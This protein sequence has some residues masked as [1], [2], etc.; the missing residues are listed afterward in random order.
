MRTPSSG[1]ARP[2]AAS[3]TT[4]AALL[5]AAASLLASALPAASVT[6]APDGAPPLPRAGTR[7]EARLELG[8]RL[9]FDPRVSR[10]GLR[11]CA[12][13][14]DPEHGY[15]DRERRSLDD[16]GRTRRHSQTLVDGHLNPNVHWDGAFR[17]VG[18]AV[19]ARVTLAARG[20]ISNGHE[21]SAAGPRAGVG[22]EAKGDDRG[23]ADRGGGEPLARD[24]ADVD[25]PD[26]DRPVP[27]EDPGSGA[28]T[29]S[30]QEPEGGSGGGTGYDGSSSKPR[31]SD[32]EGGST[33][34]TM[35]APSGE[36]PPRTG[37][38]GAAAPPAAPSAAPP[39]TTPTTP[40]TPTAPPSSA[41][42]DVPAPQGGS[43]RDGNDADAKPG[44]DPKDARPAPGAAP[45][46]PARRASG[47]PEDPFL[48][49]ATLPPEKEA[50]LDPDL[51]VGTLPY[52]DQTLEAAGRYREAFTAAF[53]T[54]QVTIQRIAEA[55]EAY[56]HSLAAGTSAYDRFVA[57]D[58]SALSAAQQRGL[59]LFR[60][61]AGCAACHDV[62]GARAAFTDFRFHNTGVT[63]K[64]IAA[65][66]DAARR[67]IVE[68]EGDAGV[69]ALT[70]RPKDRRGFK[71]PTLRDVAVRAPYMHDGSLRTLE[72]VVRHYAEGPLDPDASRVL[73]PFAV[74][75]GEVADLVAFLRALTSDV[76][77]GL[78]SHAWKERADTTRLRV[79]DAAGRPLAGL[80]FR[81]VPAGDRLPGARPEDRR[82]VDLVTDDDGRATFPMP[83]FTHVELRFADGL[84]PAAGTLVP[85][86]CREA[87]VALPVKGRVG[88]F[89]TLPEGVEAPLGIE[90]VHDTAQVYPDRRYPRTVLR[91]EAVQTVGGKAVAYYRAPFRTDVPARTSLVLP[92]R[93][94]G[95]DR[96]RFTLEADKDVRL[97]L[98]R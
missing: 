49:T 73:R 24:P 54:P 72:A 3:F 62:G 37:E 69:A 59:A 22:A 19:T 51:L 9:F 84:R 7:E 74:A 82:G 25:A 89:L 36:T 47:V 44:R 64:G 61:R 13:C 42:G 79:V 43:A 21:F 17:R 70:G 95:M 91:R 52:A 33:G 45:Q 46:A 57:G 16:R 65:K 86:T 6:A 32:D 48:S 28:V 94:W 39:P 78:A 4:R 38:D 31:S 26:V 50:F 2:R 41:G 93:T 11:S 34:P 96:M 85:D 30:D 90:A 5:V 63:W 8:R 83:R 12:D 81:V 20:R 15:G 18:D 58:A 97:D 29:E 14:H 55:I 53:G 75:P 76:R 88:M 92:V 68:A 27:S 35:R 1:P 10:A 66:D 98:S 40:A 80:A 56:C 23:W 87:V 77:P 71:T 67:A 60:G